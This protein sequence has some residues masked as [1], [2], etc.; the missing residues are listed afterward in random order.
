MPNI[1]R[2]FKRNRNIVF[3]NGNCID[4]LNQMPREYVDL[5]I[6]S[7]PYCIGK[8]YDEST[9][10]EHFVRE[11]I[12]ILPRIVEVTRDGGSICWQVGYHVKDSTVTPLDYLVHDVF[13]QF[14]ELKLRNRIM[15]TFGHGT[16][17]QHRFSGRHEIILWYTKGDDY[18]FD[19]DAVRVAQS[20]PGKRHYKGPKK[21]EFSGNPLGKNPSDVWADIPNVKANHIEKT[22]HPCQFPTA[23]AVRLIRA[24]TSK[25]GIVL[26]PFAGSGTTGVAAILERRKFVGAEIS[27]KYYKLAAKR[28]R[29]ATN[30]SISYRPLEKAVLA[31]SS[32]MAVAK[33]P[34]HFK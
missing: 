28:I 25:R 13:K 33:K 20:Y 18:Y 15:W 14:H 23:L 5:T 24:L 34:A 16:H 32:T 1:Y 30:G 27:D 11:H 8:E 10:I 26:D 19:L 6:T 12:K 7:P 22:E 21:G 29:G 4:L 3:Y 9:D 31:P 17:G 2:T